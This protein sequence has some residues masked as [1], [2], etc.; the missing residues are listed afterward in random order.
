MVGL[1]RVSQRTNPDLTKPYVYPTSAGEGVTAY[2][3]DTGIK[4]DHPDFEG[5]AV[6]G[7]KA[8]PNYG[9]DGNG[10]G[11]HCAGTIGS[12]TWGVAKKVQLVSVKVLS[13]SGSGSYADVLAGINW[14]ANDVKNGKK[15]NVANMS[16][17]GPKNQ[18]LNDAME[19]DYP[20]FALLA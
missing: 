4:L 5:R 2:V 7:F 13:D 10:H 16:L 3:I 1:S 19:G 6:F 20:D 9:E 17:G 18:Q 8:K 11:T 15:K 12:K 14:V